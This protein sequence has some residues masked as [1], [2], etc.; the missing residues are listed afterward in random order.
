MALA[1]ST[2]LVTRPLSHVTRFPSIARP[3]V[4]S[5]PFLRFWAFYAL[6][7][8]ADYFNL[9][10]YS[11][12][13]IGAIG[14]Y[15]FFLLLF[16][17]F[18]IGWLRSSRSRLGSNAP[19]IFLFFT[20]VSLIPFLTQLVG[21][22]DT[23]SY[24]S[25]F[26]PSLIYSMS[27][28][29]DPSKY[30]RDLRQLNSRVQQLLLVLCILYDGELILRNYSG[31]AYFANVANQTNHLKSMVFV[32]ALGLA[33]LSHRSFSYLLLLFFL[34]GLSE[35]LR[36]SS[37]LLLATAACA[38]LCMLIRSRSIRPAALITYGII[39]LAALVPFLLHYFPEVAQLV[40]S[41]EE[42]AK[43]DA[44]GGISNSTV[45]LAIMDLAFQ[46]IE[47]SS[48]LVGELFSGGTSVQVASLL[49]FWTANYASG[50][51][52][53][54]SDYVCVL[55]EGGLIGYAA[56][57]VGIALAAK[58]SL[59]SIGGLAGNEFALA[60]SGVV[61]CLIFV[62]YCSANPMLQV[63]QASALIWGL[64]LIS[65]IASRVIDQDRDQSRRPVSRGN[66][67]D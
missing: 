57:N 17:A 1:K 56:F 6:V 66:S 53:I 5:W 55:L 46:R 18:A 12:A 2:G 8:Y 29:F 65:D 4:A 38:P 39:G 45:R 30:G 24:A 42:T 3:D 25:A 64:F 28:A 11:T 9:L 20:I 48:W 40:T 35:F 54:H 22:G 43:S 32:A 44:L 31:L 26:V 63:Y 52:Q 47:S 14:K 19:T 61:F 62:I 36:P 7:T 27:L 59:V 50:L 67:S 51:A 37:S 33:Y 34:T 15:A 60:S 13:G 58:R 10:G 41:L 16:F 49:S 21:E 23:N